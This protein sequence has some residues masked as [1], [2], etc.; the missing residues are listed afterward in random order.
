MNTQTISITKKVYVKD[1]P[2][3]FNTNLLFGRNG[4]SDSYFVS[5]TSCE[6]DWDVI[7]P[8]I[9]RIIKQGVDKLID[10]RLANNVGFKLTVHASMPPVPE[11]IISLFLSELDLNFQDMVKELE[12]GGR[13]ASTI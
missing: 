3:L 2:D 6:K 10:Q 7:H 8:I 1:Q 4:F 11:D 12:I 9:Q 13:D 5:L